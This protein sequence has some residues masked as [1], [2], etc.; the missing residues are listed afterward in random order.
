[1]KIIVRKKTGEVVMYS[2][3]DIQ[4]DSAILKVINYAP[5]AEELDS[6][7]RNCPAGITN[8]KLVFE[9]S[10][11]EYLADEKSEKAKLIAVATNK[12]KT[13]EE[14]LEGVIQ[15]IQRAESTSNQNLS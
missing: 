5:T 14:R 11:A 9:K 8:K 6:L 2:E 12:A 4:V 1:M 3:G 7:Q 13:L 10:H 15:Y